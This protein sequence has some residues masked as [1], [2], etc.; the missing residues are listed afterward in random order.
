MNVE[1]GMMRLIITQF[2]HQIA[3]AH[4]A[5]TVTSLNIARARSKPAA[6]FPAG[7]GELEGS[8]SGGFFV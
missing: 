1:N 3:P 7:A 6:R 4:L 2:P 5:V 8:I